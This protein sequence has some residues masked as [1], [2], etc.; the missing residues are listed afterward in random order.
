MRI[1]LIIFLTGILSQAPS[2]LA[3][4][5]NA[6]FVLN[7]DLFQI[8]FSTAWTWGDIKLA[9]DDL[10][11][12]DII[13]TYTLLE[14]DGQG[15]LKRLSASIEYPDGMKGSFVTGNLKPENKPG[16]RRNFVDHPLRKK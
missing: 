2:T 4:Q 11:D 15:S 7:K 1:L 12:H 8:K 16:F 13:L 9:K 14:F 5:E 6:M 10:E 3:A